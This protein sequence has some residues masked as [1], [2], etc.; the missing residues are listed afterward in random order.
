MK[1]IIFTILVLACISIAQGQDFK[2]KGKLAGQGDHEITLDGLDGKITVKAKNGVFELSGRA[3]DEPFVTQINTTYDRNIYLGGGKSGMYQPAPP[4]EIVISKGAT[5]LI[6]G[7]VDDLHL[8]QVT[9]DIFN[10]GFTKLRNAQKE[11]TKQMSTL[12]QQFTEIRM[13]GVKEETEAHV[14]KMMAN[15]VATEKGRKSFIQQNPDLFA[16]L[17]FLSRFSNSYPPS[18]LEAAYNAL[19]ATY[20]TTNYA[21]GLESKIAANKIVSEGGPMPNFTKPDTDG[22]PVSLSDFRGKYV[23]LDFWGSW[24]GPCRAANPHLKELYGKYKSMGFEILGVASEKVKSQSVAE[25]NWKEAIE[26]DGLTWV[27]VL[28]DEETMKQDVIQMY[29]I[30]AYPTQILLDKD[31][32]LIARWRGAAQQELDKKLE[33]IFGN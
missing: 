32:K 29:N 27:N 14:K 6:D 23:L 11:D 10:E 25:K 15:R 3:A 19:S 22:K 8:A 26:K 4:L 9:G 5:I 31:G 2:I 18:E 20:K 24:C 30:E 12:Q 21:K 13:M 28:N 16:S 1:K 33:E 7:K 17:Y